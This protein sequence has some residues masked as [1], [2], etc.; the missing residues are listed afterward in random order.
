MTTRIVRRF[1]LFFRHSIAVHSLVF[2]L[3]VC[4]PW[5]RREL[6]GI[7]QGQC[8]EP[9]AA[10]AQQS[11]ARISKNIMNICRSKLS[12][13]LCYP[14]CQYLQL[15]VRRQASPAI[16]ALGFL[17]G[18]EIWIYLNV[19]W[20]RV[21]NH[22]LILVRGNETEYCTTME[23]KTVHSLMLRMWKSQTW[24]FKNKFMERL[25]LG[26]ILYIVS[27]YRNLKRGL[28]GH[29]MSFQTLLREHPQTTHRWPFRSFRSIP[30][31]S[32]WTLRLP[33]GRTAVPPS[34][35][36]P[37]VFSGLT[38]KWYIEYYRMCV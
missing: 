13:C 34:A 14:H 7:G 20:W 15:Q 31:M 11:R 24:K 29:F 26:C 1:A 36:M 27:E 22:A 12:H 4:F 18:S 16:P 19:F 35:E 5:S 6:K 8:N 25:H 33:P 38:E 32:P 10:L 30:T 9:L 37:T 17:S 28:D 2:L 21:I 23:S 3:S